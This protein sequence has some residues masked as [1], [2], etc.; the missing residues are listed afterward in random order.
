MLHEVEGSWNSFINKCSENLSFLSKFV[1]QFMESARLEGWTPMI[2]LILV[3]GKVTGISPLKIRRQFGIRIAK[4]LLAPWFSPDLIS[5]NQY[6]KI[7]IAQTLS[8]L[9]GFLRCQLVD[10]TLPSESP[11]LQWLR[12]KYQSNGIH[13]YS[14]HDKGRRILH[15]SGTWSEFEAFKGRSFIRRFKKMERHLDRAGSWRIT[16][17]DNENEA[18]H[19]IDKIL[20]VESRSWKECRRTKMG[21]EMD[22]DLMMI[23]NGSQHMAKVEPEF[24]WS[25]WFLELGGQTMAYVLVLQY[26]DVAYIAKTSYDKRFR[27]F[28]PGIYVQNVAIR[29]LFNRGRIRK[30]DFSTDLPYHRIWTSTCMPR[31]RV[32]MARTGPLSTLIRFALAN[33]GLKRILKTILKPL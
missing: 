2:L 19:A 27:K 23:W 10:L 13:F 8:F 1:E 5:E 16:S 28:S 26:K 11:N 14:M 6:R 3:D 20:D 25:A 30:I 7:C 12:Q 22:Q 24:S 29:E 9:F 32:V 18:S 4:F 17:I 31:V 33:Q 15:V 21:V